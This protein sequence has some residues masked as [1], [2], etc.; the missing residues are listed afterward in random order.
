MKVVVFFA[1]IFIFALV[2]PQVCAED[3]DEPT[4]REARRVRSMS[5]LRWIHSTK[6]ELPVVVTVNVIIVLLYFN[7]SLSPRFLFVSGLL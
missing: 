4:V 2:M 1:A 6:F 3:G 7:S 5:L